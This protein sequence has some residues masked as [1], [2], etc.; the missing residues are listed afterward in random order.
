MVAREVR[1]ADETHGGC[2]LRGGDEAGEV[3]T[4]RGWLRCGEWCEVGTE[5]VA[6]DGVALDMMCV[7]IIS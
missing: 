3:E 6:V 4:V 7:V 2:F 1:G 5:M